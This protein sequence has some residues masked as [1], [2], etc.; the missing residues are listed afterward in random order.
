MTEFFADLGVPIIDTDVIAREVVAQ[1]SPALA[2][3]RAAFGGEVFDAAGLLDRKK[4]RQVV[5]A[6]ENER[7]KLESILHPRIRDAT[8][9]QAAAVTGPYMII[10]V[11]LLVESPL[12]AFVDRVLLV[13]CSEETQLSRLLA[14]DGESESQARRIIASQAD[15]EARRAIAD[16]VVLNDGNLG[17]TRK[18]VRTLDEKYRGLVRDSQR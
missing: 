16:D 7:R 6:D 14:R 5:F 1:G 11:P 2:E 15:R 13:D 4:M 17:A 8:I 9:A 18:M 3:I 12:R 10:V